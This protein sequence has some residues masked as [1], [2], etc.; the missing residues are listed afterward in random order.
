VPSSRL[1][2]TRKG[3]E[4]LGRCMPQKL[5]KRPNGKKRNVM[6]TGWRYVGATQLALLT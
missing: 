3:K 6:G 1:E 4:Y 5:S 2:N